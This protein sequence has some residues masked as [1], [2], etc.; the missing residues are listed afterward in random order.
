M[1]EQLA[2][3]RDNVMTGFF[4]LCLGMICRQTLRACPEEE[5]RVPAFPD[6][7]RYLGV[8]EIGSAHSLK[9]GPNANRSP[10]CSEAQIAAPC[11]N[12]AT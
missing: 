11:D 9:A 5:H 12:Q 2:D 10:A 6:H 1:G 4:T 3:S 8:I 7:A